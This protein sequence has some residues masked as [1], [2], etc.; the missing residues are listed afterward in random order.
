M[1]DKL[2]FGTIG[3]LVGVVVMQW[4]MPSGQVAFA[5]YVDHSANGIIA[6][7]GD[8]F[9]DDTGNT[10]EINP[11]LYGQ[12]VQC[13]TLSEQSL[14]PPVPVNQIKFWDGARLVTNDNRGWVLVGLNGVPERWHDCGPWPGGP[15]STQQS[16]WGKI[17]STFSGKGDK[18]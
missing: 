11:G 12:P 7:D 16:T 17:K 6:H 5:T 14:S 9:L 1:K 10:W 13:W 18:Q 8:R 3:L 15:V 2:L 4:S